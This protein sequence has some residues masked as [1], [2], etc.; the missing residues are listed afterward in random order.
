MADKVAFELVS[1]EKLLLSVDAEM[2]VVPGAEGD[3]AVLVG[4]QPI[5][6]LLRPGSIDIYEGDKITERVFVAGGFVEFSNDRLTVLAEEA[7]PFREVDR[8]A[9]P[10]RIAATRK[11]ILDT[12]EHEEHRSMME[13]FLVYLEHMNDITQIH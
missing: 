1:P 4:H 10:A 2:V 8:A 5:I 7:T 12:P 3:F 13:E 11:A 9:L 6:S